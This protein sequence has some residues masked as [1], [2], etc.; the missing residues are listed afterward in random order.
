M[1]D[2][3]LTRFFDTADRISA[4][5][6]GLH[7]GRA[8]FVCPICGGMAYVE[9]IRG[10]G[11]ACCPT[12]GLLI[13]RGKL[14]SAVT[15]ALRRL[16]AATSHEERRDIVSALSEQECRETLLACIDVWRQ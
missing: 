9:G 2:E 5:A 14:R 11:A 10:H 15:D 6:Y 13:V 3:L 1:D 4:E 16:T 8:D 7:R 12:C